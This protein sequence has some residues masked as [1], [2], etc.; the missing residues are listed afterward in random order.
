MIGRFD[1]ERHP[2]ADQAAVLE[3]VVIRVAAAVGQ[4]DDRRNRI[5]VEPVDRAGVARAVGRV[6]KHERAGHVPLR[7]VRQPDVV[8]VFGRRPRRVVA[9]DDPRR[10]I[11]LR[12]RGPRGPVGRIADRRA[13]REEGNAARE[14]VGREQLL[15]RVERS[16][17]QQVD[18]TRERRARE[19]VRGEPG[20]RPERAI[21]ERG[22][23]E[24]VGISLRPSP[25]STSP[26]PWRLSE[27]RDG[28]DAAARPSH[29]DR[30]RRCRRRP[31]RRHP[32]A[33]SEPAGRDINERHVVGSA[34]APGEDGKRTREWSGAARWTTR[35]ARSDA[36]RR[37][38]RVTRRNRRGA[39]A[40][41]T[42]RATASAARS[43]RPDRSPQ[44]PS[45]SRAPTPSRR[46]SACPSRPAPFP[47]IEPAASDASA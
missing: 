39:R 21:E 45:R 14:V 10:R 19:K 36:R 6:S 18:L 20:R 7:R 35:P 38:D 26:G 43:V 9:G 30:R 3:V 28:R 4:R 24:R 44:T 12:Q 41:D 5:R 11:A 42:A 37:P 2:R 47:A 31:Q 22:R 23:V 15:R 8:P 13:E 33:P 40:A 32:T 46:E 1:R 17:R 29:R 25:A 27:P 16:G 34:Q